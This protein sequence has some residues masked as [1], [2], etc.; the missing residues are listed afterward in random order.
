MSLTEP[1]AVD[2]KLPVS[3]YEKAKNICIDVLGT[4]IEIVNGSC[5]YPVDEDGSMPVGEI[6]ITYYLNYDAD[7]EM[8]EKGVI[9]RKDNKVV[10]MVAGVRIAILYME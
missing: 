4:D 7:K 8:H 2:E 6:G 10:S 1:T 5:V 3:N 9:E